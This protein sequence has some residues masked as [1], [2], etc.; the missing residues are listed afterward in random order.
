[1]LNYE[2]VDH[3]VA[4]PMISV[5]PPL[6]YQMPSTSDTYTR[7][8]PVGP[9]HQSMPNTA[10]ALSP[11]LTTNFNDTPASHSP[12]F[13]DNEGVPSQSTISLEHAPI[14]ENFEAQMAALGS[15]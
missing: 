8:D 5:T 3:A 13:Y 11:N 12:T 4:D 15:I 2:A 6:H 10:P 14:I 9:P 1:M 7:Y